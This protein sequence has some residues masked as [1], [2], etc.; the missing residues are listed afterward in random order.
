[1]LLLPPFLSSEAVGRR[2]IS[3]CR[4]II[5]TLAVHQDLLL[6][7]VQNLQARLSFLPSG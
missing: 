5:A 3:P 4:T 7:G 1:M 2:S 6:R